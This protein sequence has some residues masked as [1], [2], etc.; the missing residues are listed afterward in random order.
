MMQFQKSSSIFKSI[1]R[2]V[3]IF[4]LMDSVLG[5]MGFIAIKFRESLIETEVSQARN[6]VFSTNRGQESFFSE[7][8]K[9]ANAR[10]KL[11]LCGG[12][13][14]YTSTYHYFISGATDKVAFNYAVP[15]QDNLLWLHLLHVPLYSLVGGV[16]AIQPPETQELTMI[17][18]VCMA[19]EPGTQRLSP[20]TLN[21]NQPHCPANSHPVV[22]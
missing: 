16:F 13:E 6:L 18:I 1:P 19:N 8:N 22:E 21:N 2:W 11:V 12:E 17:T 14:T 5:L 10:N 7:T 4:L 3:V 20:P 15:L 9:F